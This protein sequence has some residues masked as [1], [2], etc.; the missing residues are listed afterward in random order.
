MKICLHFFFIQLGVYVRNRY[1]QKRKYSLRVDELISTRK[2]RGARYRVCC[3]STSKVLD[4]ITKRLLDHVWK[5]KHGRVSA[6]SRVCTARK[7]F[8]RLHCINPKVIYLP[9]LISDFVTFARIAVDFSSEPAIG[10]CV[11]DRRRCLPRYQET[12]MIFWRYLSTSI[13]TV[14]AV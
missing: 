3:S 5:I 10:M 1:S 4:S 12:S 2:Y 11:Y 6:R 9:G 7:I 14:V 8:F 13:H